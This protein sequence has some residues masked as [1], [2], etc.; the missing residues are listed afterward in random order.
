MI[1]EPIETVAE[2]YF[3]LLH[4]QLSAQM[5]RPSGIHIYSKGGM[6][7]NFVTKRTNNGWKLIM[8]HN[9]SYSS[10]AMGFRENG[11]RLNPRGPL[12]RIN[13]KTID[14]CINSV[15]SI[16]AFN[17]GGGEVKVNGNKS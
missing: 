6:F 11:T 8:S 10:R 16:I 7:R 9:V 15:S 13:F 12:E 14:N 2:R 4:W 1:G 17:N 5:P 3:S